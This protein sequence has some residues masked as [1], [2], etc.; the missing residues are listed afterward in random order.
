MKVRVFDRQNIFVFFAE[1]ISILCR[2]K[3]VKQMKTSPKTTNPKLI[4]RYVLIL[5]SLDTP[6]QIAIMAGLRQR[7]R[8]ENKQKALREIGEGYKEA[9]LADKYKLKLQDAKEALKE[10]LAEIENE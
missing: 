1:N 6:T 3:A 9:L 10:I 2:I 7:L 5:S 8:A 4:E